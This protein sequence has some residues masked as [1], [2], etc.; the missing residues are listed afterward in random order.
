MNVQL[1]SFQILFFCLELSVVL[2]NYLFV[3]GK[4]ISLNFPKALA[5]S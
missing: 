4:K 1:S 2:I 3:E 5:L